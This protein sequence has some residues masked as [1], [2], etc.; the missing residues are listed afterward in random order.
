PTR[1]L[2]VAQ[3]RLAEK[4]EFGRL[5]LPTPAFRHVTSAAELAVGVADLG[6]PAVL[7]TRRMG[8]DGRGQAILQAPSDLD[9]AWAALE[10]AAGAA[11]LL[12]EA[13]V[14]FDREL[15]IIAVRSAD[16]RMAFYPL[17]ENH[18]RDGI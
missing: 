8:Y 17:V 13:F 1:A 16:G 2:E 14:H 3:D 6:L 12:L 5:G 18:H 4:T 10:Q 9:P 15:S 7:K 11:G